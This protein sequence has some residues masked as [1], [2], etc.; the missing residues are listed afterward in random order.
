MPKWIAVAVA[1]GCFELVAISHSW[2]QAPAPRWSHIAYEP[3]CVGHW[4]V[5]VQGNFNQCQTDALT[6]FVTTCRYTTNTCG[7]TAQTQKK[8]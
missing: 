4:T 1:T 7:W 2:A 3:H 5:S 8:K 6:G